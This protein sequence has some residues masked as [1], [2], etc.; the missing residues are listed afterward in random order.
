[1][2]LLRFSRHARQTYF[3]VFF[4]TDVSEWGLKLHPRTKHNIND[5]LEGL[6][7]WLRPP[8]SVSIKHH[9]ALQQS[10]ISCLI[11]GHQFKTTQLGQWQF[12]FQ[13]WF[14]NENTENKVRSLFYHCFFS[15]QWL[16]TLWC[17]WYHRVSMMSGCS[18]NLETAGFIASCISAC[19]SE[20]DILLV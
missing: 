3:S 14:V 9:S 10:L 8:T 19:T 18:Q 20:L 1:M 11:L 16:S 2:P 17:R 13:E 12:T 4:V 15:N 5:L 7:V 6:M